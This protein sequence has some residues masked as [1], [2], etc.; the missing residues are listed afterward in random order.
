MFS[1]RVIN[2]AVN[3]VNEKTDI[4]VSYEVERFGRQ[5]INLHFQMKLKK[6]SP[7][8]FPD[9]KE[10]GKKLAHFGLKKKKIKELLKKHDEQYLQANIEVVEK[11]SEK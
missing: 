4:Q 3:E 11:E 10:I 5:V 1:Q 8:L 9:T 6:D 2:A 7:I